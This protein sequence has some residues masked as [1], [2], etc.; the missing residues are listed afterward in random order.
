MSNEP[1]VH[2]CNVCNQSIPESA[3]DRGCAVRVEGRIVPLAT[4][5]A[6][7]AGGGASAARSPAVLGWTVVILAAI[8]GAAF[9]LDA[10]LGDV[11]RGLRDDLAAMS[12]PFQQQ[13]DLLGEIDR[14]VAASAQGGDLAPLGEAIADA[15]EILRAD[16]KELGAAVGA[17]DPQWGEARDVLRRLEDALVQHGARLALVQD[18]V[19]ARTREVAALSARPGAPVGPANGGRAEDP[20]VGMRPAPD[21][22]A[23]P[24]SGGLPPEIAHHVAR[25]TDADDGV[26]FEAV[27]QLL[28][29]KDARIYPLLVPLAK[30]PDLF[31]RRFVL[32]GLAE[33]RSAASVEALLTAL[34]DPEEVVRHTAYLGLQRLTG[35]T[36]VFDPGASADQRSAAQRRWRQWWDKNRDSY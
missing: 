6:G 27:D 26:R 32:E 33:H 23:D 4:P 30:D 18:E 16:V 15:R 24:A 8:A 20:G 5:D 36:I 13:T 29:S 1:E 28:Q 35:Q 3:L 2:F 17:G 12:A 25:L 9:G 7:Q 10:R 34:A 19:R 14:R 22:A 31:V 11:E 21:R